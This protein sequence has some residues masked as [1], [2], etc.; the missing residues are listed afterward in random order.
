[1][2]GDPPLTL[3][4]RQQTFLVIQGQGMHRNGVNHSVAQAF[5]QALPVCVIA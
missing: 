5:D 2:A 1:M 3:I 4:R